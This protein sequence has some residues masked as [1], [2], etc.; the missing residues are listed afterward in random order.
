MTKT[1]LSAFSAAETGTAA[2]G[3]VQRVYGDLRQRIIAF[4]LPP[5]MTLDRHEL[6]EHYGVSL[7]PLREALQKLHLEGLVRVYPQSRTVVTRI[8]IPQIYEAHFLRTALECEVARNLALKPDPDLITRARSIIRMQEVVAQDPGQVT[9][10]QELD[11]VFHNTMFA[12][13]GRG[14][15]HQLIRER[16][17]HL[18]RARRLHNA[19]GRVASIISGHLAVVDEIEK[20]DPD[21]A[22]SAMRRHLGGT[23][24]Q[25][26]K[27]RSR[28]PDYFS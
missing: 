23:I 20:G 16:S 19:Q 24:S 27:L 11:E 18:E 14:A 15:L 28:H 3:T 8:D 17:G 5:D 22:V 2:G 13:L 1:L 9:M 26:E 12:A 21:A 4:E 7:T 25:V 10:F 6:T